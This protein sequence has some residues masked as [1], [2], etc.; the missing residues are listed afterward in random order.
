MS[1]RWHPMASAPKDGSRIL[2]RGPGSDNWPVGYTVICWQHNR[3]SACAGG[4]TVYEDSDLLDAAQPT[5]WL[6][7]EE[8]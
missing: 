5:E 6:S 8:L 2:A 7:L 4:W 3:W 1:K